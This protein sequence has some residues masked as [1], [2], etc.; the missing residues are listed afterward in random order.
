[1]GDLL[2]SFRFCRNLPDAS[3]GSL[4]LDIREGRIGSEMKSQGT[5]SRL[6]AC[7]TAEE[8]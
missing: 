4:I 1:M 6:E 8:C 7:F 5:Q 3:F 2:T